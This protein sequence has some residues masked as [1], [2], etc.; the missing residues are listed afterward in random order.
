MCVSVAAA[1]TAFAIIPQDPT[2]AFQMTFEV[3]EVPIVVPTVVEVPLTGLSLEHDGFLVFEQE[4]QTYIPSYF[5]EQYKTYPEKFTAA[6]FEAE[7]PAA[8][9]DGDIE[10]STEYPLY[11]D[12]TGFAVITLESDAP[13]TTSK[14]IFDFAQNV[15]LPDTIEITTTADNGQRKIIVAERAISSSVVVF[16]ETVTS[17][18]EITLTYT[19]PLRI[20]E[21]RVVQDAVENTVQRSLRFLAQPEYAYLVYYNP[22]RT[23]KADTTEAGNLSNNEGVVRFSAISPQVNTVYTKADVD[24]DGISDVIDNCPATENRDQEDLDENGI[25]DV[26][27]DF[28]RDGV[29][30]ADDNCPSYPNVNQRD[31]DGDEMGDVCDDAESRITERYV[32]VPWVGMGIALAVLV[33]L[34]ALVG[35]KSKPNNEDIV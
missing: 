33:G 12:E 29:L 27:D 6:S 15:T 22:D 10:T 25:G 7:V 13:V 5:K 8:L 19:Q 34:F 21:V 26:C 1:P 4:T 14:L 16:P 3:A 9:T 32:W 11:P 17:R 30:N 24:E 2:E 18:F 23:Y 35:L 31:E 20:N 28:D